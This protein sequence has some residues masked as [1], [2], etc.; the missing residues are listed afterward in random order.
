MAATA[1]DRTV[2]RIRELIDSEG[3]LREG[4]ELGRLLGL[5]A[6]RRAADLS[7]LPPARQAELLGARA[8]QVLPGTDRLAA[9]LAEGRPLTVKFGID[10][11]GADVHLGH[12]VPMILAGRLQRMGHRVVFLVGDIT[13][14]IGDPSGRSAERPPL[15]EQDVLR[16]LATYRQQVGPF[17]DFERA[18]F[19]FNSEWLAPMTLPRFLDVLAALPASAAL[20]RED[21]RTR[22]AEGSGLTL[23]EL[24]Y[25]VV[26]ALDS[27][28]IVA[29]LE[30]GGLD[31]L[32]NLQM[33]RRVMAARGQR[34]EVVLA[35]ALI[36]GTD[37][38]GAKMSKSKNNFV[39]LAFPAEEM[40][41]RLM[42]CAD[43]L[44]PDYLRALTE[45]LDEEVEL[46]LAQ[47]DGGRRH[48]MAVKTL[49][50]AAV[51][52]TVHGAEAALAARDAFRARYS[53]R[54]FSAAGP[55]PA[56]DPA[57]HG[58]ATLGELLV[59]AAG[60]LP[61]LN[62]V[63]RVAGAGGL[64]LVV[65]TTDGG[66]RTVPLT[67]TDADERLHVVL[68]THDL[69]RPTATRRIFLRCGRKV[70]ELT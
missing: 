26:M 62:Q 31:Q 25:S 39:G 50:A 35:T 57:A 6:E 1:F 29:D 42:S 65:E 19:R 23:A 12:A 49:L 68:A 8:A 70:L 48:P 66:Q 22:L 24:V 33:C 44:L 16:N 47:V 13:A 53:V 9:L 3:E 15:T 5:L 63:R 11:T 45:L 52:A 21:F 10:P 67:R 60:E 36:E 14:R 64:R 43:R 41:G 46:L 2:T 18:E 28:E 55:L 32:L 58:A 59:K 38:T 7:G 40:F 51:T 69:T 61:S 4:P 27:V 34:P 17:F 30:L 54:R 20:Q 56:A 37:G